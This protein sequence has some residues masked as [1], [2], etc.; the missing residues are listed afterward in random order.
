I[1]INGAMISE[2]AFARLVSR[3]AAV[4]E[5][6]KLELPTFFEFL[7]AVAFQYFADQKV[8]VAIIETGLG[9]RLD[10][11]NVVKPE[12]CGITSISY[13]HTAILGSTLEDIAGEKAGIFKDNVP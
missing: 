6:S 3:V 1:T 5:K 13:D 9:G 8:D 4:V 11:T 7:T 10:A 12:V 2:S